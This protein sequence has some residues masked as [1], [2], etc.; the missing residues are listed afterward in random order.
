M[1]E[2]GVEG[3]RAKVSRDEDGGKRVRAK[4]SGG[5]IV[6]V[7]DWLRNLPECLLCHLLLN[8]PT[9]DVVK[10]CTLSSQWRHLWRYVP[11][12]DLDC[13]DFKEYDE[14]AGFID[15]FL[16]FNNGESSIKMFKLR[17]HSDLGGD[18]DEETDNANLTRWIDTVVRRKVQ[19]LALS[20]G[21]VPIPPTL[22]KS[23]SLVSLK[24][25]EAVLPNPE[26]VS[27]PSVK[28]ILLESVKFANDLAFEKLISGCLGLERLTLYRSQNDNVKVL[29]VRSKSLLNFDYNGSTFTGPHEDLVVA[30]DAPMLEDLQLSDH[31]TE[32]FMI[33]NMSSL[34]EADIDV[35]FNFCFGKKFDPMDIPKR[36]IIRNFLV[37]ISNVKNMIISPSTLEVI[38]EYS[39]C[40]L[41]PLFCNL[42]SLSVYFYNHSWEMLPVFLE[43]CPNV[44]SLVVES[45]TFPKGNTRIL[46]R[47]WRLLSSLEYA[48]IESPLEGEAMEMELLSYLLENSPVL[49]R[50]TLYVD[51]ESSNESVILRE[52]LM[53]PRL[54]SSCQVYVL[55]P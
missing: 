22:Y 16:S 23:E 6:Q 33:D 18:V 12:L 29:R 44:K 46:T 35:Q 45:A 54:S 20:W 26:F 32:S 4:V 55:D 42:S 40:E 52:L 5:K 7:D 39:K 48:E 51:R 36:K 41:L 31:L 1:E 30:I 13:R 27:L 17:Y 28:A 9:K 24:L 47:P 37:A 49:R 11:G 50:L 10:T 53:I 15:S 8:L 34:K 3:V 19:H 2:D 21:E 43:R 38:Y 25:T 14:V